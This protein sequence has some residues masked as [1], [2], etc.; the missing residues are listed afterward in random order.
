M[1]KV[2]TTES[3]VTP[4][5]KNIT[6]DNIAVSALN[7]VDA[8]TGENI[9][10]AILDEFPDGVERIGFKISF[11]LPDEEIDYIDDDVAVPVDTEDYN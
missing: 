10:D 1:F 11:E 9:T 6:L 4:A 5:K 2:K 8:D 7:F 3:K